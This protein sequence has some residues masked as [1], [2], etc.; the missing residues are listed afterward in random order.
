VTNGPQILAIVTAHDEADRVGAT[1]EAIRSLPEVDAVVVVDDGSS[2]ATAA[3]AQAAGARVLVSPRRRGKGKALERALNMFSADVYL[4]LDADLGASAKEAV[5][6]LEPVIAG[7]AD[8]T[9]GVL[10][11]Q[12]AHGGFRIV[13]RMVGM[14]IR[15]LSG[16]RAAEPMSGQRALSREAVTVVRPLAAGFGVELGITVDAVR[17]GLRVLEVAVEMD[18]VPTGRDIQGF[19]HR[20]RQGLDHLRAALPRAVGLR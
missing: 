12:R 16:F 7:E 4:L 3:L 6:L 20:L 9:V 11:R 15:G 13:K 8:M 5:S 10:P 17:A 2:D 18:H 14:L 19:L 1:V